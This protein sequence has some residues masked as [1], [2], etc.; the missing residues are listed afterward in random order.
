MSGR[1]NGA[2]KQVPTE[3]K[4]GPWSLGERRV[5]GTSLVEGKGEGE[6]AGFLREGDF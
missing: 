3:A 2:R 5:K 6:R 4:K 1:R